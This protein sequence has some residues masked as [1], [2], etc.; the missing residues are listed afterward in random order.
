MANSSHWSPPPPPQQ[1]QNSQHSQHNHYQ[2]PH[3]PLV[4]PSHPIPRPL[5]AR[6]SSMFT[7]PDAQ[8]QE[9]QSLVLQRAHSLQSPQQQQ[10]QPSSR[11]ASTHASPLQPQS[12]RQQIPPHTADYHFSPRR[13]RVPGAADSPGTPRRIRRRLFFADQSDGPEAPEDRERHRAVEREATQ[14]A[15]AIIREAVEVG[16]AHIDLSDLQLE[17]VPDELAELKDLVV[18]APSQ[19]LVTDLQ[20]T[21]SANRLQHF[22]LAVCELTNLTTLI[23]SHN[24]IVHLPP[25]IGNLA[26][27]RELSVAHNRLRVLPLELTRLTCLQTLSV[28]PNP[29]IDPPAANAPKEAA[30]AALRRLL[31][32]AQ[33]SLRPFSVATRNSGIPRLVDLAARGVSR[34]QLVA[35]KHRLAQCLGSSQPA[36]GRI[37]GPAIEPTEE[38]SV[39]TALRTHHLAV[40]TGHECAHCSRWFLLPA[41]EITVWAPFSLLARPAPFKARLCSRNC[42]FSDKLA[43]I[44]AKPA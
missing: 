10:Q 32:S 1:H 18:L 13:K 28:F 30:E 37:V 41:A 43:A 4:A 24:R 12:P 22:P 11:L 39:L 42:L 29:F 34:E 33:E 40:P 19:T 8:Q 7:L 44:L 15:L 31:P 5:A 38:S 2:S 3:P 20:L 27:L 6:N 21:L 16:D 25:E 26:S 9:A 35:L 17:Q 36:L 14:S 23:L